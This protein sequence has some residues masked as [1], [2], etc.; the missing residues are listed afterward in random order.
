MVSAV[1]ALLVIITNPAA[2]LA[3]SPGFPVAVSHKQVQSYAKLPQLIMCA[4]SPDIGTTAA[5]SL[6]SNDA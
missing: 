3:G 5:A 4:N 1:C 2:E 6:K